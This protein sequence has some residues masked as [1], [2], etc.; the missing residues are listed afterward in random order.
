MPTSRA[1]YRVTRQ[2]AGVP[3]NYT[4][5]KSAP[6]RNVQ[7]PKGSTQEI[8]YLWVSW[9]HKGLRPKGSGHCLSQM[10][11]GQIRA[12]QRQCCIQDGL[13]IYAWERPAGRRKAV[14][15]PSQDG[16]YLGKCSRTQAVSC[17]ERGGKRGRVG[18]R[19]EKGKR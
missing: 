13:L 14:R 18:G 1:I 5:N 2:E 10:T 11:K 3:L 15:Q 8:P 12:A 9:D 17:E 19:G 4:V 16:D 7:C 6:V